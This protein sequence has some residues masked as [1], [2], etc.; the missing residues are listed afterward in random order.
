MRIEPIPPSEYC[1]LVLT[2]GRAD[3]VL[4]VDTLRR[5]GCTSEILLVID[6]EDDQ[7]DEYREKYDGKNGCR[8]IKFCKKDYAEKTDTM[9]LIDRRDSIVFARNA[10]WD[11]VKA[12]GYKGFLMFEDDYINFRYRF[13]EKK[14]G[15]YI[16]RYKSCMELD[17]V[18]GILMRY[19]EQNENLKS[20]CLAQGGDFIRGAGSYSTFYN[21]RFRKVMNSFF[22]RTDRPF[23]FFGRMNDDV[24][25]YITNGSRGEIF[26]SIREVMLNQT[27]TQTSNSG[28]TGMYKAF[29]TYTKSFYSVMCA[30]SCV[31]ISAMG[32]ANMRIHHRVSWDH[33]VPKIISDRYKKVKA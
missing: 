23:T 30:P 6:D 33:A 27:T 24:N 17:T 18:F 14:N 16:L 1:V 32:A 25:C 28:N 7:E 26:F 3:H 22:C 20:I 9:D 15:E 8:V 2:H 4:T 31:S 12:E 5:Y 13:V 10:C 19:M 21:G 11:L 29:G